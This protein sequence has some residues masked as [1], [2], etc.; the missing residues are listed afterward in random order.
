ME[1][2]V[3][4]EPVTDRRCRHSYRHRRA[5]ARSAHIRGVGHDLTIWSE[6]PRQHFENFSCL[7][8]P[9]RVRINEGVR[10]GFPGRGGICRHRKGHS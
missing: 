2:D 8:P 6:S 9:F 7:Q 3:Q 1:P 4:R 10:R 5:V